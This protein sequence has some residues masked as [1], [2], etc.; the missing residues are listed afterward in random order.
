MAELYNHRI[1]VF[2]ADTGAHVC[3]IGAGRGSAVGQLGCPNCVTL[4]PGPNGSNLLFVSESVVGNKR[5][6][7]FVV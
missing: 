3:M 7:V 6:Q 1:Q 2:D 5:V 4:H